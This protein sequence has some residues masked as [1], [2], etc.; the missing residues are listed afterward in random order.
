MP[1]TALIT[2]AS[3][4]IGRA[5]AIAYARH[6]LQVCCVARSPGDLE[7]TVRDI[8]GEGGEAIAC[9]ADVSDYESISGACRRAQ[10]Q[11]GSIDVV[12]INAGLDCAKL[13]VE[14]LA[15]DDWQKVIAVNLTGAFFTAKAAIPYLKQTNSGKIITIGSGMGHKGR[16]RGAPYNCSKAALWMLTR[17][18]AQ[19]L[20]PFGISVNELLPGP[21]LTSLGGTPTA[22]PGS[23]FTI[24]G[25]WIKKPEDVTNLA[26]F[27]TDLPATGPTAQSFSL[28][29]RD[30]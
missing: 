17:T 25:E 1:R 21:V 19:E 20:L 3:R 23:A 14:D 10:E 30:L 2:G 27:M 13:P 7:S 4:G 26:L 11:Y 24:E 18:L 8:R 15:I 28:M 9:V 12:V 29:R 22:D 5:I 16:A 6:G